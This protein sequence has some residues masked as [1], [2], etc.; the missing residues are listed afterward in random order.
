MKRALG[1]DVGSKTIGVAVTDEL[2]IAA[3]PLLVH[4][5]VGTTGDVQRMVELIEE[6]D[7]GVVIVGLPLELSGKVG[8]RAKRVRVFSHALANALPQG[9]EIDEF[10]ER[11]STSAVERVLLDADMSRKHRKA[12]VDKQAAAFIL[13]GWMSQR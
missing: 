1:L 2:G 3:H 11:F 10:D 9:I 8:H 7:V 5:R 6:Y 4:K 12:V 13:Q